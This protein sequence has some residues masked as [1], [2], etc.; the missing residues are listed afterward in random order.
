MQEARSSEHPPPPGVQKVGAAAAHMAACLL[1]REAQGG[2]GQE[3][4][5][6]HKC[7]GVLGLLR[8]KTLTRSGEGVCIFFTNEKDVRRGR[9]RAYLQGLGVSLRGSWRQG[10]EGS[11]GRAI[12][13]RCQLG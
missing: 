13:F 10:R 9:H 8:L 11:P 4:A 7:S 1:R 2:F 12:V 5:W 3:L 6:G